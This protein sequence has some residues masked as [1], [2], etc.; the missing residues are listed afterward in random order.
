MNNTGIEAQ[1]L[2]RG[3]SKAL[4]LFIAMRGISN[5]FLLDLPSWYD[6]PHVCK[7]K[8]NKIALN[9]SKCNTF[10]ENF[11]SETVSLPVQRLEIFCRGD[12]KKNLI[13]GR[14][15]ERV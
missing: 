4:T 12:M 3:S 5:N 10:G 15:L 11:S 2:D 8:T 13:K 1:I 9:V 6:E 14:S 7:E